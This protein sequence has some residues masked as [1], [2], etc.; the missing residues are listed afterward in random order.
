M[1]DLSSGLA[2]AAS[3]TNRTRRRSGR[4]A[5]FAC[6]TTLSGSETR[7]VHPSSSRS[8]LLITPLRPSVA[9]KMHRRP[10]GDP[11]GISVAMSPATSSNSRSMRCSSA[12][13]MSPRYHM[14]SISMRAVSIS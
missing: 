8:L 2:T 3:P 12:T 10:D 9:A 5:T 11:P 14:S 1:V 13:P 7:T 6:A 4:G